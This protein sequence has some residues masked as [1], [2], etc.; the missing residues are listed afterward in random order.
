M[1]VDLKDTHKGNELILQRLSTK[2]PFYPFGNN[3]GLTF[4]NYY[5]AVIM[6]IS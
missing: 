6:R 5:G 4:K 3:F 1:I 2:L